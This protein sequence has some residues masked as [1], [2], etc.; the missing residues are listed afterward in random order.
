MI[1][2]PISK[3]AEIEQT[4]NLEDDR[5]Q[6]IDK[7]IGM[8]Y[9]SNNKNM[10]KSLVQVYCDFADNK[11]E[12]LTDTF[13]CKKWEDYVTCVHSVKS[14]ALNIGAE[15]LSVLAADIEKKGL[16]YLEGD[17]KQL[18]YL[19][20]KHEDLIQLYHATYEEAIEVMKSL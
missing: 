19:I 17:D 2:D 4:K 13:A 7:T 15:K 20:K 5:W 1:E 11:M 12:Q 8:K 16:Q 9:S 6:Y 18:E 3:E 10:Y 14:T